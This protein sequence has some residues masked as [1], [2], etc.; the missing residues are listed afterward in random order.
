MT[1]QK[2]VLVL[3]PEGAVLVLVLEK[4][5]QKPH[6]FIFF[7]AGKDVIGTGPPMQFREGIEYAYENEYEYEQLGSMSPI[8]NWGMSASA[9]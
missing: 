1:I 2:F 5:R 8:N 4:M 9:L 6:V 7:N 3:S